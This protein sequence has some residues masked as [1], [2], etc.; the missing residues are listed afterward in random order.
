[1]T[2]ALMLLFSLGSIG[3]ISFQNQEIN[4][5][6][7]EIVYVVYLG[8]LLLKYRTRPLNEYKNTFNYVFAFLSVVVLSF[9]ISLFSFNQA[10]NLVAFLYLAR[11]T[12]YLGGIP[13][14]THHFAKLKNNKSAVKAILAYAV[15]TAFF[16]VIQY[17]YYPNLRNLEY[18][19]W[20]PHQFRMFGTVFDTSTAA[21]L[22]GLIL[23]FLVFCG[24]KYL[25]PIMWLGSIVLYGVFGALTYSRGFYLAL[26]VTLL[27]HLLI[28]NKRIVL[29]LYLILTA[30]VLILLIPKPTGESANLTRMFTVQARAQDYQTGIQIWQKNPLTGVGYN[31][32]GYI[33]PGDDDKNN[34][35]TASLS[36]SFLIILATTGVIGLAAYVLMLFKFSQ[37]SQ[38]G[39]YSILFLSLFSFSDNILLHPLILFMETYIL[40]WGLTSRTSR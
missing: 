36:S 37:T 14:I 5:Y 12:V 9:V 18:L 10:Q 31:H 3:R 39:L 32:L 38:I 21:A 35:A 30:V 40:A 24:K 11:L 34:H 6:L 7:Y 25:S 15:A 28:K 20:D 17:A 23:L 2:Y 1:M 33:K 13:Y 29:A 16:S 26:S 27:Y 4:L 22:Y 8:Y 19:G